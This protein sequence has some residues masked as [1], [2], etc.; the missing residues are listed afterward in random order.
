MSGKENTAPVID[1]Q[2]A[3]VIVIKI[4]KASILIF[5]LF[6]LRKIADLRELTRQGK[7]HGENN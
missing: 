1:D 2:K 4:R 3:E 6:H 5:R 7:N